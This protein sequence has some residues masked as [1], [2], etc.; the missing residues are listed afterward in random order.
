MNY[1]LHNFDDLD[2]MEKVVVAKTLVE[3]AET[4]KP[5]YE[6]HTKNTF[7]I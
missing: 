1:V 4:F 3:M 6:K 5:I 2:V 7:I